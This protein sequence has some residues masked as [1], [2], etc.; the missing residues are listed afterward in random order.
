MAPP[1]ASAIDRAP[2]RMKM[3][4]TTRVTATP[5]VRKNFLTAGRPAAKI[6]VASAR[7]ILDQDQCE[8]ARFAVSF[9]RPVEQRSGGAAAQRTGEGRWKTQHSESGW[10]NM[11]AASIRSRKGAEKVMGR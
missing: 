6:S 5:W 1:A 4:P 9:G 11:G 3:T 8:A 7:N 10:L 2:N